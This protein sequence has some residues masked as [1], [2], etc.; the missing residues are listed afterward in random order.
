MF[1]HAPV[2]LGYD[3]L[4]TEQKNN[5][6]H[7]RSGS[8]LYPSITTV[9]SILSQ[10]G[11]AKW[12]DKVGHEEADKI[13]YRAATRGTAVHEIIEKY[14]NN[15][16]DYQSGYMPNIIGNFLSVK[17]V[18]DERIGTVYGQELPL[19]SD[20]LRVAG[21]VDCV[22]EF[23]GKNSIIDFK[24]SRKRKLRKYTTNYFQQESAYAIMWE[25]RTRMPITQ[26]VTIIAVD[27][28]KPQVFI[29]HRDDWAPELLKTIKLFENQ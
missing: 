5:K 14:I 7:Y 3:D 9:L 17:D 2:D 1:K 27:D 24:T 11:I 8:N 29:E 6:R 10:E 12:R 21:R 23:D 20:H 18:L 16:P 28:S 15:D 26:L 25:E 22:A 13:S 4:L 19:F